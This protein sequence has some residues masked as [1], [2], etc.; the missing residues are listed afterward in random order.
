MY[1]LL[2]LDDGGGWTN[3]RTYKGYALI[4]DWFPG[5]FQITG[6]LSLSY[7]REGKFGLRLLETRWDIILLD[8]NFEEYMNGPWVLAIIRKN[9]HV[10]SQTWV[11]GCSGSWSTLDLGLNGISDNCKELKQRL[12][13]FLTHQSET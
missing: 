12:S 13:E 9:G 5:I 10:N 3:D 7:Q 4:N 1:N 2:I 11:I 8:F 6:C